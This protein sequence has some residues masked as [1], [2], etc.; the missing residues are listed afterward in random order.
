MSMD[1]IGC[2]APG[3]DC[4]AIWKRKTSAHLGGMFLPYLCEDHLRYLESVEPDATGLYSRMR[5]SLWP[6]S[7]LSGARPA[8]AMQ[9]QAA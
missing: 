7:L 8:L 4:S 5:L 6:F 9:K 2:S 3:C 1:T